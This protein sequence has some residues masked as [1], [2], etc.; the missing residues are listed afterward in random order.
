[1]ADLPGGASGMLCRDYKRKEADRPV[2][3][4]ELGV[5]SLVAELCGHERQA[6]EELGQ[7]KT[8]VEE[9]KALDASPAAIRRALLLTAVVCSRVREPPMPWPPTGDRASLTGNSCRVDR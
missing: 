4:I 7:W 8:G 6:A 3:R 5:V 2:T 1:M 9:R